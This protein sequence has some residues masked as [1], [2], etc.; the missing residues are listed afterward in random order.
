M[1][2]LSADCARAGGLTSLSS[3]TFTIH[4]DCTTKAFLDGA[5][6]LLKHSPLESIQL[7][8][9]IS[10]RTDTVTLGDRFCTQ[11]I[12]Q[13]RDRLIRF[14]LN[15]LQLRLAS[16]DRMCLN[17][18]KLEQLFMLVEYA[19]MV[20]SF[21]HIGSPDVQLLRSSLYLRLRKRS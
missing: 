18:T 17:C 11:I 20:R 3:F 6:S 1:S 8:A 9:P 5:V 12:D 15:G 21:F 10:S 4:P 14:A 7:N 19:E 16:I 13:H 2:V